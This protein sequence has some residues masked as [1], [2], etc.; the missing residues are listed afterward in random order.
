MSYT[1]IKMNKHLR[2]SYK[3]ERLSQRRWTMSTQQFCTLTASCTILSAATLVTSFIIHQGPLL[4]STIAQVM[5]EGRQNV[6]QGKEC[7]S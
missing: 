3:Q 1:P 5:G 4:G 7:Q 2:S 6:D